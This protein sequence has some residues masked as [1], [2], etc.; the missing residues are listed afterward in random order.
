MQEDSGGLSSEAT[1]EIALDIEE[2]AD[3]VMVKRA[4]FYLDV[5]Y[6]AKEEFRMPLAVY[7][8]SGEYAMIDV[9][10]GLGRLD[11]DAIM[12]ESLNCLKRAGAN[13]IVTYFAKRATHLL[14]QSKWSECASA[15]H[16][17]TQ[18]EWVL[19]R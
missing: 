12:M 5:V 15:D 2:G 10:A 8:V 9:V 19:S 3:I 17:L 18:E 7:N 16:D 11:R 6:R 14:R 4:L 1:R 13:I